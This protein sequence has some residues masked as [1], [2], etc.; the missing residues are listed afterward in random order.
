MMAEIRS[1]GLFLLLP[2]PLN[3]IGAFDAEAFKANFRSVLE[4]N[5]QAKFIGVNLSGLD[6]VYS[7]AYN[8]FMQFHQELSKRKGTFAVLADKESLAKSLKKVGLERFIRIFMNEA[9]MYSY[10]PVDKKTSNAPASIKPIVILSQPIPQP[11]PQPVQKTEQKPEPTPEPKKET[12]EVPQPQPV[13]PKIMD[14]NP[15]VDETPS[16]KG[17]L[18]AV[19]VLLLIVAAVVSYLVL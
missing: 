15:L 14:K 1:V 7:D 18:V 8:A 19:F 9:D 3:P 12:V 11:A 10:K 13:E 2:A 4:E 16:S 17:S 6:F 5:P